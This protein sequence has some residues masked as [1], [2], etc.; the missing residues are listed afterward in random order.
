MQPFVSS[1]GVLSHRSFKLARDD[2][3]KQEVMSS[4]ASRGDRLN[5]RG[6]NSHQRH[7]KLERRMRRDPH[8][9]RVGAC[10]GLEPFLPMGAI[11]CTPSL[12]KPDKRAPGRGS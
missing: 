10:A 8:T 9:I 2:P 1:R 5:N 7:G 6:E 4:V 11:N 12:T 3:A